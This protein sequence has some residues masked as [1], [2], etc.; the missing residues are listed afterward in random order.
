VHINQTVCIFV[1]TEST[2]GKSRF[3]HESD[4]SL[5]PDEEKCFECQ[6]CTENEYVAV[7]GNLVSGRLINSCWSLWAL[8]RATRVT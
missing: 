4:S 2:T 5:E 8:M 1:E 6:I 3:L 7:W